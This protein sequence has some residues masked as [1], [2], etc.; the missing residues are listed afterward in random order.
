MIPS[1]FQANDGIH[2]YELWKSDGTVDGTVLAK[3]LIPGPKGSSPRDFI[4]VTGRI[5]FLANQF[6]DSN[7]IQ[8]PEYLAYGDSKVWELSKGEPR[9]VAG[10]YQLAASLVAVDTTV[11]FT[12]TSA[13]GRELW[14][15]YAQGPVTSVEKELVKL[16]AYPNPTS[17]FI[18]ISLPGTQKRL[19]YNIIDML[20]RVLLSGTSETND[21]L[22]LDL[23]ALPAGSYLLRFTDFQYKPVRVLKR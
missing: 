10:D 8:P 14:A 21:K 11:F 18:T 20:G 16:H 22:K 4:E 15:Y 7:E 12:A 17:R 3:D 1:I 5:L 9:V 23:S 13:A 19:Q 6:D 2:G